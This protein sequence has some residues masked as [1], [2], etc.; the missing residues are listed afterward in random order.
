MDYRELTSAP[1]VAAWK[2]IQPHRCRITLKLSISREPSS[3]HV[4]FV[5][6]HFRAGAPLKDTKEKSI[7]QS[8]SPQKCQLEIFLIQAWLLQLMGRK[9]TIPTQTVLQYGTILENSSLSKRRER[10]GEMGKGPH[11]AVPSVTTEASKK[12]I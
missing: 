7:G 6:N 9:Q 11:L 10:L 3:T 12:A 5:R 4:L 1:S 8:W 2:P